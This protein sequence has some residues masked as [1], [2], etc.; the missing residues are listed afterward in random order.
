MKL[1]HYPEVPRTV[2]S[3]TSWALYN[4]LDAMRLGDQSHYSSV[5][6]FRLLSVARSSAS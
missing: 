4:L 3:G 5:G 6:R 1:T 2:F